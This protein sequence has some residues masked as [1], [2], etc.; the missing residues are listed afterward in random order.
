MHCC[1]APLLGG[2]FT[3][4][5]ASEPRSWRRDAA[6]PRKRSR[7]TDCV[8]WLSRWSCRSRC[9]M[10]RA[11]A[12][13]PRGWLW[14]T[15]GGNFASTRRVCRAEL[16]K[17]VVLVHGALCGKA[18]ACTQATDEHAPAAA[19]SRGRGGRLPSGINRAAGEACPGGVCASPVLLR[20]AGA[21]SRRRGFLFFIFIF[22]SATRLGLW[23]PTR[24]GLWLHR[25]PLAPHSARPLAPQAPGARSRCLARV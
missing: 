17:A 1:S 8:A 19:D 5:C 25:R 12:A 15:A 2:G 3:R 18:F 20:R 23:L 10:G 6:R 22:L 7:P 16:C 9:G 4:S 13:W 24:L 14:L 21:F 11:G